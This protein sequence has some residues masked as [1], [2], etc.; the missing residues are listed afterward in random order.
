MKKWA[1][2]MDGI[3][4][5]P[6]TNLSHA[7]MGEKEHVLL[8]KQRD[9]RSRR[10]EIDE[11]RSLLLEESIVPL[12]IMPKKQQRKQILKSKNCT[13]VHKATILK[14]PSRSWV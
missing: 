3:D 4:Y 10:R 7:A 12:S 14:K 5:L 6:P 2:L 13:R 1:V 9:L 11:K 8:K